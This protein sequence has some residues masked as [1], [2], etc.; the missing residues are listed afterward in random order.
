M[1]DELKG[2]PPSRIN[3]DNEPELMWWAKELGATEAKIRGA[4]TAVGASP[5]AVRKFLRESATQ[6]QEMSE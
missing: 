1:T 5:D 4:V 2:Q 3:I 6:R